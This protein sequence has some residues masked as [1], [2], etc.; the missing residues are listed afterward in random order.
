MPI[1][2]LVCPSDYDKNYD[3]VRDRLD[4]CYFEIYEYT[5]GVYDWSK[6]LRGCVIPG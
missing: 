4:L 3:Y 6:I 1:F 2:N 5:I